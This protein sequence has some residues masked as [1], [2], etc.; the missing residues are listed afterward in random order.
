MLP[1]WE[2]SASALMMRE[3][4]HWKRHRFGRWVWRADR[5]VVGLVGLLAVDEG[6]ELAW[7]L[8]PACWGRGY[9]TEAASAAVGFAFGTLG[10]DS[11]TAKTEIDN[12][13]SRAVMERL[14]MVYERDLVHAGL[15]HQLFRLTNSSS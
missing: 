14:G 15:P 10:L 3:M 9:A 7:F 1:W 2:R 5:R 12:A 4:A 8:D 6:V 13:R 11:V